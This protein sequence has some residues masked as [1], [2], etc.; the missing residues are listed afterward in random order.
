MISDKFDGE[1]SRKYN[2]EKNKLKFRILDTVIDKL[3]I[4]SCLLGLLI[5]GKIPI[6]YATILFGY[7][8]TLLGGG[9]INFLKSKDKNEKTV[10]GLFISRLFTGLTGISFLLLNN[11]TLSN[12]ISKILTIGMGMLGTTSLGIQAFDKIKQENIKKDNDRKQEVKQMNV[13]NIVSGITKSNS[14]IRKLEVSIK[15]AYREYQEEKEEIKDLKEY[16]KKFITNIENRL[17]HLESYQLDEENKKAAYLASM[18]GNSRRIRPLLL[19]LGSLCSN[20]KIDKKILVSSGLS[21]EMIH[22]MSLI[23][24]DYFDQDITRRG[25]P[26][27]HTIFDERTIIET[28]KLLLDLSNNIFLDE[29][30][31]FPIEKRKKLLELYK[32]IIIDMGNGFIEDLDREKNISLDDAY[33]INDLQSTTIL[34]NSL[35]IG[36]SLS[37]KKGQIDETYIALQNIGNGIGKTFQGFNDIENF[38]SEEKQKE[39]KGDSYS[40]LKQNRKNIILGQIPDELFSSPYTQEDII[41]YIKEK[42]LIDST[43]EILQSGIVTIKKEITQLPNPVARDTLLFATDKITA[44]TLKKI[45]TNN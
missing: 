43:A 27:F 2:N 16:E 42:K 14:Y 4:I 6:S 36:Y 19:F 35:L 45:K 20:N 9:A 33:R 11:F 8:F 34:R 3:G 18:Q 5:T 13:L 44:K 30:D 29:I 12:T 21:I 28:A 39:N 41:E 38:I 1:I 26:T 7:N 40:D 17:T 37:S 32:Q 31:K 10:Q 22:K 25:Y 15:P 24:D 23:L